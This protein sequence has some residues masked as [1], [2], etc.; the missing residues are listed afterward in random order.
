MRVDPGKGTRDKADCPFRSSAYHCTVRSGIC[1]GNCADQYVPASAQ[2]HGPNAVSPLTLLP[3]KLL[4]LQFDASCLT[5]C[6]YC[7]MFS[8]WL[9]NKSHM[10]LASVLPLQSDGH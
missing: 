8:S 5:C 6:V 9:G 10:A 3:L 2:A 7:I 1:Y 4:S